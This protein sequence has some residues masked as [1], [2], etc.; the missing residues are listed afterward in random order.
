MSLEEFELKEKNLNK[1]SIRLHVLRVNG[2]YRSVVAEKKVPLLPVWRRH[3][4]LMSFLTAQENKIAIKEQEV[5]VE[6]DRLKQMRKALDGLVATFSDNHLLFGDVQGEKNSKANPLSKKFS[7]E[8]EE[9]IE[10]IDLTQTKAPPRQNNQ[11]Q[12]KKQRQQQNQQN[13]QQ[14]NQ[15]QDQ[16]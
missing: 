8:K 13:Q 10:T 15:Q 3:A 5:L 7:N 1:K 14:N 11:Q 2:E 4:D 12:S 9:G 16:Q 6:K